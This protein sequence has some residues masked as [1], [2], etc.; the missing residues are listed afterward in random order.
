MAIKNVLLL[1][2]AAVSLIFIISGFLKV[3]GKVF[4]FS[5]S[6]LAVT[7]NSIVSSKPNETPLQTHAGGG[8]GYVIGGHYSD[9]LSGSSNVFSLQC[10]ASAVSDKVRVVEQFLHHGY[11]L[12]V[13]LD[14]EPNNPN[15]SF[16]FVTK[17][18]SIVTTNLENTVTLSDIW[19]KNHW[20]KT[21]L[22]RQYHPLIS[23]KTFFSMLPG[24]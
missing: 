19:D 17:N 10:W 15:N 5:S 21:M 20:H 6:K 2:F 22:N 12:G 9:Q 1:I 11:I 18:D 24:I 4:I 7:K 23:W 3:S 14:P 8:M 13:S 16:L